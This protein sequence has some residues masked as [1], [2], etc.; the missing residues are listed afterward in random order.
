MSDGAHRK[1]KLNVRVTPNKKEEWQGALDDDE[2]LSSLVRRS[3][4]KEVK[5]EYVPKKAL[6]D[7]TGNADEGSANLSPILDQLDGLQS[8]LTSVE[9]KIDT[10]S[11]TQAGEGEDTDI[12]ELAMDLLPH[13]PTYPNDIPEHALK[14]TGGIED[15]DPQEYISDM[16]EISREDSRLSI[17]GSAQSLSSGLKEPTYLVREALCYLEN[18]TTENVHSALVDGK[19]HWMRL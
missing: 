19:R 15:K 18:N 11:T 4:D 8:S 9:H 12:E 5:N 13:L 3:V 17:D 7:F 6:E 10:I 14:G 2:T 1:V 16:V